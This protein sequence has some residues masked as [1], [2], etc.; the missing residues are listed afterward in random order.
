M[1][2][3]LSKLIQESKKLLR[4]EWKL[5]FYSQDLINHLFTHPYTRNS[6]VQKAMKISPP[7]AIKW[8]SILVEKGYLTA[9]YIGRDKYYIN[10]MLFDLL[11][12]ND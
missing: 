3:E 10:N 4:G 1:I 2:Q 7:T 5:D 8:L 9:H 6:F 11:T 12:K